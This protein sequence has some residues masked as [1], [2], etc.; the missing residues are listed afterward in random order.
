M[1]WNAAADIRPFCYPRA[2]GDSWNLDRDEHR[3]SASRRAAG[4]RR[5]SW[6]IDIRV[7]AGVLVRMEGNR[8][9][10]AGGRAWPIADAGINKAVR[11]D[12]RQSASPC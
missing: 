5:G 8:N 2:H 9:W 6:H 1:P 11:P 12:L 7:A 10:S 3:S 4:G